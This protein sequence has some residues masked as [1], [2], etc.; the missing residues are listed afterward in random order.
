MYCI[1]VDNYDSKDWGGVL[2]PCFIMGKNN[3]LLRT[4]IGCGIDNEE[5]ISDDNL[6]NK[7]YR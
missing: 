4:F 7:I 2:A 6:G 1:L 5:N 3:E